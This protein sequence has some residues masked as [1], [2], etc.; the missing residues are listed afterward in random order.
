MKHL[1]AAAAGVSLL[2]ALLGFDGGVAAQELRKVKV[3]LSA[4]QD[5][6][7]IHVGI[8]KGFYEEAGIELEIQNTDWPGAQELLIGGH[9]EMATTSD[10]DIVL[11]NAKGLDT[12]LTFPLFYFAGGGLMYD[13]EK[14]DWKPLKDILPTVGNDMTKAIQ[15]TL[16]QAKGARVG[17]S[18]AGA[19]YASFIQMVTIA[20]LQPTDYTIVDLAQE[21]LPPALLSGSIDIMIAGIP[22]RLAVLKEGYA[23]LMDQTSVPSTV[24][25]AGFGTTRAWADE[26]MD[27]AVKI[28]GVI[29]KTLAYVEQNP[30]EAFPIISEKLREQGT[31][32][33]AEALHGVWNNMEFFPNSKAWYVE[34]VATPGGQ[35]YWKDRFETIIN[36]LKAEGRITE[37]SVP[38]EDLNYGLKTVAAQPD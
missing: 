34:K 27:L 22:Q 37:L 18:A 33:D 36:N 19:E 26:N 35:F 13:P 24:A 8:A 23:T 16:E 28:E 20:G 7:T 30:D 17:V 12:T 3:A 14:H 2:S 5:V 38:L 31:E 10:A 1:L 32:V 9:V 11:Q 21:E 29:L 15:A 6:N 25:H 4:F